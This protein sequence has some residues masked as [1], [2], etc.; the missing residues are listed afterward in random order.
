MQTR[1]GKNMTTTLPPAQRKLITIVVLF[2]AVAGLIAGFA[3]GTTGHKT[4]PPISNSGP[5]PKNSPVASTPPPATA[6]ATPQPIVILGVPEFQPAPTPLEVA[7]GT[8]SYSVGVQAIDKQNNPTS[9]AN[10]SC[11]A[12]LVKQIPNS[13]V[14]NISPGILKTVSNLTSPITGMVNNMPFPEV[15]GLTYTPA[16]AGLC[17]TKGLLAWKYTIAPTVAAGKYDLVVLVDWQGMH[18][19]WRWINI[20]IQQAA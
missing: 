18:W 1:P 17:N 14:L 15:S 16:Q 20:T 3:F 6:T 19:N 8:T 7:D 11:K 2:F 9:A 4:N 5:P 13:R 10:I 12:W